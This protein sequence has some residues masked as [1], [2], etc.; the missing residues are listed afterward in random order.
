MSRFE[1]ASKKAAGAAPKPA[2]KT[3]AKAKAASGAAAMASK[4]TAAPV[5]KTPEEKKKW[6][7]T[8]EAKIDDKECEVQAEAN[9]AA[10]KALEAELKKLQSD[11]NYLKIKQEIQEAE[12]QAKRD[13]ERAALTAKDKTDKKGSKDDEKKAETSKEDNAAVLASVSEEVMVEIDAALTGSGKDAA[14]AK[15]AAIPKLQAL[16]PATSYV[17]PRLKLL[18]ELFGDSKLG[19]PAIKAAAAIVAEISPK[20]HGLASEVVPVLLAGMEDKRWKVK[21]GCIEVILPCLHQMS[22]FT[23]GQLSA[24]LPYIVEKLAAAALEVRA[25]IRTATGAV[26][27]EIGTIVASPEIK[28]LSQDLV[29]ALAEP[30]NQKH[31]QGVLARMGNQTFMSL[32]DAASLALLMPIVVRGLRERE[33]ASKKW[34]AQIFGSTSQL[35]QNVDFVKP[36]LHMVVPMLQQALFDPVAEVQREAAKAYGI[37]EQVLPEYSKMELQPWLFSKLR[38]GEQGEQIGAALALAQT[39]MK[40]DQDMSE[41]LISEIQA[42]AT[43][44]KWARR[45][46]FLELMDAMPQAMKMD[47]VPFIERL[48]P[49]M[50]MGITGDKDQ[51]EDPGHRAALALTQTFGDLC[52]DRLLSSFEGSFFR[53]LQNDSQEERERNNILRE[54][55]ASLFGK[56]AEKI[57]EHKKFGQ[58]LLTTEDCSTKH[59][60]SQLLALLFIMRYDADAA[61]KRVANGIWK[62]AGG[63]PKMQKA[64]MPFIEKQLTQMRA[65]SFGLAAQKLSTE[66]IGQ[67]VKDGDMTAPEGDLPEAT[68]FV[69]PVVPERAPEDS[70]AGRIC[71]GKPPNVTRA[72]GGSDAGHDRAQAPIEAAEAIKS[73]DLIK[74][75]PASVQLHCGAIAQSVV[76]EGQMNKFSNGKKQVVE[77]T[78]LLAAVL[79]E[80]KQEIPALAEKAIRAAL[81]DLFDA[82]ASADGMGEDTLLHVENLLLMYGAGHL[83]LKD[84]TLVMNKK[85]CYGIVGH[86]GAGKTTL[87][88]EIAA[89]RIVGMPQDLK[90]VHVDDSK[91]GEMSKSYLTAEEYCVKMAK[92]IGVTANGSDV[93]LGVGFSESKLK[94]PVSDLSTG[95]RMRLTLAVSMLKHADLVLLDEPTNHLDEES[96]AWLSEYVKSIKDSSVM[97]ISH[98]PKFLNKICTHVV[99]YV[100]KKL[101]YTEGNFDKFAEKKGLSREQIDAMLSGNLS[102]DT[103]KE[104]EDEDDGET[105]KVSAPVAGPP[106]LSFPI[107]GACEGVKTGSKSVMEIKNLWFRFSKD[108]DYLLQNCAG[109]LSLSSRVAICGRNGCGK[110]TLMTLLCSEL[111]ASED[112]EGKIGEV[113]RHCNLRLAYMKQDHLKALGPFFDTSPFVYISERFKD[114]YD[115]DLQKRLIEP[116][117]EEE[118][119]KRKELAKLHGKYGNEVAD[120]VS[121]TKI[122]NQL[123]YEVRW[124]GLDDPK[125]NTVEP[126]SKLKTMG[127]D[128]VVIACD[129]RIAAKA[130][131]LDQRPLTRREIIR[132]CEAF[133][134]DEEMCCNRQIRG[135]SA[136]QKVRL[137]LAAMFWTKPHLIALDEPTNYLDVETVDALGKAL[138]NFRGG[139]V[140]IE[141]KSDF[142]ARICNEKWNM[143]DGQITIE[144]LKNGVKRAA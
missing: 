90:C 84:T 65:G 52:P 125:Q 32:I 99:A 144:K 14:A 135:F 103:K 46:G 78:E 105:P 142:V 137:S 70:D 61:V 58:D 120:L 50:L 59:C 98:E 9:K 4:S 20:G 23:P 109:K 2:A 42:G 48:F 108:K 143:E 124:A 36:Y 129:E 96:V 141:P 119:N 54:K 7:K 127:L 41:T 111:S 45:R 60:R 104:G 12:V 115:G 95:W 139:I 134:I 122:G 126:L 67:L 11:E 97:V 76:K 27:R 62:T 128:K 30:T 26:L 8:W 138:T 40:M 117:D 37:L 91:L 110:S 56:V 22:D 88:K 87:M 34:S 51:I 38:D 107:P 131:G 140:M 47:F 80:N 75:L 35:V 28:K 55:V 5:L 33:P 136:G 121:R 102:F 86:N 118:A 133:G 114:G 81:G 49:T 116:E 57:L 53:A 19:A 15:A 31:T 79:P 21:A 13:A 101:E 74:K 71:A 106:K 123:A 3:A 10:R 130:A 63:A 77:L 43:D 66:I 68:K 73:S 72:R 94:D 93:L 82:Q 1:A 83:L 39:L 24:T 132:H 112:K 85:C 92:D 44:A 113:W 16:A 100:D 69:F 29:T 64:I 18:V 17:L 25:E 6:V 89:H